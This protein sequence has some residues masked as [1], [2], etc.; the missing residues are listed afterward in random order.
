MTAQELIAKVHRL[1]TIW[2]D[3]VNRLEHQLCADTEIELALAARPLARM[4]KM[5]MDSLEYYKETRKLP[6][7]WPISSNYKS[8]DCALCCLTELDRIAGEVDK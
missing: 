8:E 3:P 7:D 4:L 2:D 5:A 1:D 6:L